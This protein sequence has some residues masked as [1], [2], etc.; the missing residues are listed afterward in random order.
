[1]SGRKR[2]KT[3]MINNENNSMAQETQTPQ[4]TV[5]AQQVVIPVSYTHLDVYKRQVRSITT[6]SSL[7]F[8][9]ISNRKSKRNIFIL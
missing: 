9:S 7:Y 1:M 2:Q 3:G 5:D 8:C 4:Q 6:G